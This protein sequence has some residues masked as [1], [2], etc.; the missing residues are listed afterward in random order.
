MLY[1]KISPQKWDDLNTKKYCILTFDSTRTSLVDSLVQ[2]CFEGRKREKNLQREVVV[3]NQRNDILTIPSCQVVLIFVE[4]N[5]DDVILESPGYARD[6]LK[7]LTV[8]SCRKTN[9]KYL[10]DVH[11]SP[12]FT[13]NMEQIIM[14]QLKRCCI[15]CTFSYAKQHNLFTVFSL[16]YVLKPMN[17]FNYSIISSLRRCAV[18][19]YSLN[20]S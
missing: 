15:C 4:K 3:V 13:F 17:Q 7:L 2:D 12:P 9:G 10:Y 1:R 6:D 19:A 11:I 5:K 16:I 20:T 18:A 8:K 14:I